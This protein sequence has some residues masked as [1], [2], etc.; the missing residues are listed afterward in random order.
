[1]KYTKKQR[2]EAILIC[3]IAASDKDM[4]RASYSAIEEELNGPSTIESPSTLL[5]AQC[6]FSVLLMI[7][8]EHDRDGVSDAEA[9]QLLRDGWS[10]GDPVMMIRRTP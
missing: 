5:A 8:L 3:A 2:E 4:A 1:M 7:G 6:Q 10:P 9:A